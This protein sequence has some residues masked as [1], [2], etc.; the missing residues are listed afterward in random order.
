MKKSFI[1]L[2]LVVLASFTSCKGEETGKEESENGGT[3][4]P[5][6]YWSSSYSG[7][8]GI[9]IG[10]LPSDPGKARMFLGGELLY[11]FGTNCYNL[12]VQCHEADN[13]NTS[14]MELAVKE[15]AENEVP[16]VR[17]SCS[18]YYDHQMHYYFDQKQKYLANLD[19][20]GTICDEYH[21][22]LIPSVF[23]NT[24]C[25]P[26]YFGEDIQAWGSTESK[27]YKFMLQYTKEIVDVLKSHKSLAAWEFGNEFNLAADIGIAGYADLP[28][29]CVQTAYKGFAE[30]VKEND[31]EHRMICTGNSIM[32]DAQ[33]H[34]A[35]QK[36]WSTDSFNEYVTISKVMSPAPMTGLSEHIYEDPRN[37]SDLG[38]LNRT[39]QVIKSKEC[40][41]ELGQAFY[42]GEFT[43]P[44]TVSGDSVK[45]KS[46]FSTYY[47]QKVQLSMIW[48]YAL[49]GNIEYSFKADDYNGVAFSLIRRY[50][51]NFKKM[52]PEK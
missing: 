16:V 7:P 23:W 47:S 12:F 27:T 50:N 21:I 18:P 17:F 32:R 24:S 52:A 2:L 42:V 39:Q 20:L 43:G 4:A 33:W 44:K 22:L 14:E 3:W 28:A 36:N 19:K 51:N 6:V 9:Q 15:L 5:E 37:F 41:A 38:K 34:L 45:V 29:S 25:L 10:T 11:V 46:H 48:N 8:K 40:A 1:Y 13:M 31:P 35:N 26:S 49:R 30:T